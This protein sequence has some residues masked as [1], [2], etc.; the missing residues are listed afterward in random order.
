M[1]RKVRRGHGSTMLALEIHL[2]P[3]LYRN[4]EITP[5]ITSQDVSLIHEIGTQEDHT[6]CFVLLEE[7]PHSMP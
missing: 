3:I 6:A 1:T 2:S 7:A 4:T 5:T